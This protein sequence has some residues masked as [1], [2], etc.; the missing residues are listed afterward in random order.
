MPLLFKGHIVIRN[1]RELERTDFLTLLGTIEDYCRF[2]PGAPS[3]PAPQEPKHP[4]PL[5]PTTSSQESHVADTCSA[6]PCSSG[7]R[8]RTG[9]VAGDKGRW[10]RL[11]GHCLECSNLNETT[12]ERLFP[13]CLAEQWGIFHNEDEKAPSMRTSRAFVHFLPMTIPERYFQL[14]LL[15]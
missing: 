8:R 14:C 12:L 11:L 7:H 6:E 10:S 1:E 5:I 13:L 3:G 2:R 4:S 15:P 9:G